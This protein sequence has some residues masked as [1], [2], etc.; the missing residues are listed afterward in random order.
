MEN[1]NTP[2]PTAPVWRRLAALL[3]DAFILLA[4]SMAYGAIV[5]VVHTALFGAGE[6][7]YTPVSNGPLTL[8]GWYL[9]LAAFYYYFWRKDGQTLGMRAWHL[10]LVGLGDELPSKRNC[11]LRVLIS[12]PAVLIFLVGYLWSFFD[13]SGECLHDK[14]SNTKVVTLPKP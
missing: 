7:K 9:S 14:L 11:I 5:L 10:K 12:P 4:I 1:N 13:K 8:I 6:E 3:Y 2:L